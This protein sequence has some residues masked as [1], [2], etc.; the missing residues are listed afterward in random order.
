[1][2]GARGADAAAEQGVVAGEGADQRRDAQREVGT[3]EGVRG[4]AGQRPAGGVRG[5]GGV[6]PAGKP[7][8]LSHL[9]TG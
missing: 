5:G 2:Q 9:S 1:M 3:Q 7:P 4:G 8:V 6:G